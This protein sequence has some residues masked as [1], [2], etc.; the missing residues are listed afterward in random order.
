MTAPN[1]SLLADLSF[2]HPDP[3]TRLMNDPFYVALLINRDKLSPDDILRRIR[4]QQ[5]P[6][7]HVSIV[8]R[9][10]MGHGKSQRILDEIER[11]YRPVSRSVILVRYLPRR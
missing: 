1:G 3:S 9:A 2:I 5:F 11:S 4:E 6:E 10:S 8:M 7:I